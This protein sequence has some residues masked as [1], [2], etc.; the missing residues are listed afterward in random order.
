MYYTSVA[1]ITLLVV[2]FFS[3]PLWAAIGFGVVAGL[4]A[5]GR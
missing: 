3:G 4:I 1:L 5:Q 2:L